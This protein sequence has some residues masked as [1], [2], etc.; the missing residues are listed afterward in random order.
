M[1]TH[2]DHFN[3]IILRK[4]ERID[5]L[6]KNRWIIQRAHGHRAS[7]D[8]QLLAGLVVDH[9]LAHQNLSSH[10]RW[11]LDLG[12]GKGTVSL[13]ITNAIERVSCVGI[14]IFEQSY[15]QALRNRT[16]NN[17]DERYF[18]VL[19]DLRDRKILKKARAK[20]HSSQASK[21][22][23]IVGA[24]PFMPLGSGIL[25]RDQQ[26]AAGRFELNGGCESYLWAMRQL[27]SVHGIGLLLM[28]GNSEQRTLNACV[29]T[30]LTPRR[31]VRVLP[32]PNQ[33]PTYV[34]IELSHTDEENAS[35]LQIEEYSMRLKSSGS[36]SP[37]YTALLTQLKL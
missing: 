20:I 12:S 27:L 10:D 13:L 7:S 21:F 3:S 37:W 11:V 6:S 1:S 18:P 32:Y 15:D 25:P 31:L 5:R 35:P 8:D 23:Y 2:L 14:E 16:L 17:I 9:A 36:W 28:D 19:G 29:D 30:Q 22:D 4:D 34:I 26:R 24:P 33:P